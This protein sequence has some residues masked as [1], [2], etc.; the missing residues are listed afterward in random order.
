MKNIIKY[1]KL[2]LNSFKKPKVTSGFFINIP[3]KVIPDICE[4]AITYLKKNLVT[5]GLLFDQRNYY[6]ID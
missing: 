6:Y 3:L 4:V 2:L 1:T 5:S